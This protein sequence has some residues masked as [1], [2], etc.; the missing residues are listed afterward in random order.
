[1]VN[2]AGV[3][4]LE[5]E[6]GGNRLF[7]ST[8]HC[9]LYYDSVSPP[10]AA[11]PVSLHHVTWECGDLLYIKPEGYPSIMVRALDAGP[12]GGYQIGGLDI[13]VDMSELHITWP[14]YPGWA[15]V[16]VINISAVARECR[17]R[18]YCD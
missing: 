4:Y 3:T 15:E 1:M 9:P 13:V 14:L 6:W 12:F 17:E 11:L 18:G 7:C 5:S 16:E 8:P 10:W 2:G